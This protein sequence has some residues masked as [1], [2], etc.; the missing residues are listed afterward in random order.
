MSNINDTVFESMSSGKIA[1][2]VN[3]ASKRVVLA[4]PGLQDAVAQALENFWKRRGRSGVEVVL[5][6]DEE[7]IRLGYGEI[8]AVKR[9]KD[10][11]IPLRQ[12]TG[13][14]VGVLIVDSRAWVFSPTA[15]Y[16]QD[17]VHSDE[18]PNA[19]RLSSSE[20]TRIVTRLS[21][22]E[23][24]EAR[25]ENELL[26]ATG[27][28]QADLPP[29]EV[30]LSEVSDQQLTSVTQNL[31]MVPPVPFD[32]TRQVRVFQPYIQYVDIQLQGCAIQRRRINIPQSILDVGLD[33]QI[34]DRLRTT[35]DVINRKSEVSSA[36]L[37]D[38]LR[39]IRDA[40]TRSLGKPWGRVLLRAKRQ[41][42][43]KAIEEFR[44]VVQEHEKK[45]RE[46]LEKHLKDSLGQIITYY[47]PLVMERP[48]ACLLGQITTAMPTGK[49]AKKWLEYELQGVFPDAEELI[50]AM[51][52]EVHFR[53]VTFETLNEG[54]FGD[55]LRKAFPHVD[56]DKP[57]LEFNAAK[58]KAEHIKQ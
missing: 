26:S 47:Q 58:E 35:F 40:Y 45:V 48:P 9:L 39:K 50:G 44:K 34:Q 42:F 5:D 57:F 28:S 49:Q 8:N 15:L 36:A 24:Q 18:T 19:V 17:E 3:R 38:K 33:A 1:G 56:W 30:G 43:D 37:E 52:L 55:L 16:V 51:R 20:A 53:D 4:S 32:V 13:L 12:S 14:R 46:Q 11:G 6:C 10:A 29:L 23:N 2:L 54:G 27:V 25:L 31:E 22:R 41:D 21:V 7:V